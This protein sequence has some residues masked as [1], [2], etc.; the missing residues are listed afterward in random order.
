MSETLLGVLI[1][2]A[3]ASIVPIINIILEHHR[4]KR[5]AKLE[6]LKQERSQL[7]NLYSEIYK[8]L[9][10]ALD[11]NAYPIDLATNIEIFLPKEINEEFWKLMEKNK[12]G[13]TNKRT[14][15]YNVS[16]DMKINLKKIDDEIKKLID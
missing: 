2:G 16:A 10:V 4:W 15:L 13:E 1:G 7:T 14:I 11:K 5:Q 12:K 3:I 8:N 9:S 6:F